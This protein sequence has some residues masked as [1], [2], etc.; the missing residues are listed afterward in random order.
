MSAAL[1]GALVRNVAPSSCR[2]LTRPTPAARNI[3]T[4]VTE[5][6]SSR[7]LPPRP[8]FAP[9]AQPT[10]SPLRTVRETVPPVASVSAAGVPLR[11]ALRRARGASGATCSV[12]RAVSCAIVGMR[13][14]IRVIFRRRLL[15]AWAVVIR[16]GSVQRSLWGC[17]PTIVE[18]LSGLSVPT[19]HRERFHRVHAV[20]NVAGTSRTF[21]D[22][23]S[24]TAAT[25]CSHTRSL[26]SRHPDIAIAIALGKTWHRTSGREKVGCVFRATREAQ[27]THT[28][29]QE[30][31]AATYSPTPSRVQYHRRSRA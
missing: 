4:I 1:T 7:R 3:A 26:M 20:E 2:S 10:M 8:P 18:Q 25:D 11:A 13:G 6:P 23:R 17:M 22:A 24:R 9:T 28:P 21:G 16:H 19:L 31:P 15:V 29:S 30:C 5:R 14:T 12:V 27:G